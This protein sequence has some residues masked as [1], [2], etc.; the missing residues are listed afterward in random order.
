MTR[1][2]WMLMTTLTLAALLTLGCKD[3]KKGPEGARLE[4]TAGTYPQIAVLDKLGEYIAYS[5][6]TVTSS[7]TQ[8]LHVSVPIALKSDKEVNA[9]YKFEFFKADGRPA[10][11]QMDWAYIKLPA[12]AQVFLE[13]KALDTSANNWRLLIRPAR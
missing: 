1:T 3:L 11:P 10:Q 9:Q 2:T 7:P 6:P 12:R 5:S 13:G 4:E 8:P